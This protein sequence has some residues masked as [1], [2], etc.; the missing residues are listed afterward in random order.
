MNFHNKVENLVTEAGL[1]LYD[2]ESFVGAIKNIRASRKDHY[3][4]FKKNNKTILVK[5]LEQK[6]SGSAADKIAMFYLNL[7][8]APYNTVLVVADDTTVDMFKPLI[9]FFRKRKIPMEKVQVMSI[10]DFDK[11]IHRED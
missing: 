5:S 1:T 3:F 10:R 2:S 4:Y 8:E 9:N 7:Q 6:V 11:Y